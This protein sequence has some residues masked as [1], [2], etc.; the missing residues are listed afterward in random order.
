MISSLAVA[1][2]AAALGNPFLQEVPESSD[3]AF[4]RHRDA[5][6]AIL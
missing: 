3:A 6:L 1:L 4:R 5:L 2:A